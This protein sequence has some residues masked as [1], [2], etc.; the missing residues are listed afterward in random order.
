MAEE[1]A[2]SRSK[3]SGP[4]LSGLSRL[5]SHAESAVWTLASDRELLE[6]MKEFSSSLISR[7]KELE[8]RLRSLEDGID[9]AAVAAGESSLDCQSDSSGKIIR[10]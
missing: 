1:E 4:E 7:T 5:C 9:K 10:L 2:A 8:S 3:T 6:A